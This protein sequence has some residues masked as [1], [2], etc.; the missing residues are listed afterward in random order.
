MGNACWVGRCWGETAWTQVGSHCDI[1]HSPQD[2]HCNSGAKTD[3]S[4][5]VTS[6]AQACGWRRREGRRLCT[7]PRSWVRLSFVYCGPVCLQ[8]TLTAHTPGPGY[9]EIAELLL[10]AKET[11]ASDIT[12]AGTHALYVAALNLHADVVRLLL[13]A[14]GG[15]AFTVDTQLDTGCVPLSYGGNPEVEGESHRD[16]IAQDTPSKQSVYP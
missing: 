14:P 16:N 1:R 5:G 2:C 4:E 3:S 12:N 9:L 13:T 8:N 10:R 7:S 6:P 11:V 15:R